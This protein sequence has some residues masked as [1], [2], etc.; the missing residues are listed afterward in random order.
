[1]TIGNNMTQFYSDVMEKV[2]NA[3]ENMN[4]DAE[5]AVNRV[6]QLGSTLETL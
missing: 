2:N 1:M 4:D 5:R 6:E 3:F